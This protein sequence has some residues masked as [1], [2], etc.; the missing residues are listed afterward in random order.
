MPQFK[1][2]QR[3]WV[4]P[5]PVLCSTQASSGLDGAHLPWGG[6]PASLCPPVQMLLASRNTSMDTPRIMF[7][8]VYK[9]LCLG[10]DNIKLTFTITICNNNSCELNSS[11][12]DTQILPYPV[13]HGVSLDKLKA[14]H[15]S[16]SNLIFLSQAALLFMLCSMIIS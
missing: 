8:Q 5:Y 4:L 10:R 12:Q 7:H 9:H 11:S 2:R 6:P 16:S 13:F 3:K 15:S 1:D 14:S